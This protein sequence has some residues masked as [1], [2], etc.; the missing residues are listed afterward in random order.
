VIGVDPFEVSSSILTNNISVFVNN[1]LLTFIQDY[2]YEG[3]EKIIVINSELLVE[4]DIV[5]I[6]NNLRSEYSIVDNVINGIYIDSSIEMESFNETDN[7][8]IDVTWFSEYSSMNITSDEY[9][10]GKVN[11]VLTQTPLNAG[12]V[13]VYKNGVR[14]VKD[15]D[16]RL[17]LPRGVLYLTADTTSTD[18]IKIVTFGSEIYRAPSAFEIHK[19]MLNVYHYKRH[20]LG[21]V[22]LI[23][24]L[25]YYDQ[26]MTVSNASSLSNPNPARNI[27]GVVYVNGERI[28]FLSV[29]GNVL[30]Q[31][32]RG[33]QGTAIAELHNAGSNV[34]DIGIQET[35]P[36][37]ETQD[38]LDFVSDGSTQLIGPLDF[39]PAKSTRTSWYRASI[40]T[41]YGPCDTIE[42][43]VAGTRLRKDPI[44]VY[45]ELLGASSPAADKHLEAEF[46]VD[47]TTNAIYL[48]KVVPAGTRISVIRKTG[49]VWYEPG[50]RAASAGKT[51]LANK[52]AIAEFIAKRTTKL[53]E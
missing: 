5:K 32:R 35:I 47:G 31:L 28:E 44:T 50:V 26:S 40:P 53:P 11:Y 39:I 9:S 29:N 52:T 20:T 18:L 17:S 2:S 4:G 49:K 21:E 43:F 15:I 23:A 24:D 42:V 19:D 1:K 45:D 12:Y 13:W 48:T 8:Y 38:R 34:V 6:E 33:V 25:M 51:L 36:Y 27:P 16:Y 22:T 3:I 37:N 41:E 7:D 30:S 46:A 10:G 14:L